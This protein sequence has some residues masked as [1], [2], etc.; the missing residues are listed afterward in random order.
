MVLSR[1]C[2]LVKHTHGNKC[3]QLCLSFL[4]S[5]GC[6]HVTTAIRDN[7]TFCSLCIFDLFVF[8]G[9]FF[10]VPELASLGRVFRSAAPVE[11]TESETEY[12]VRCVKHIMDGYVVLDFTISNTIEEQVMV[13]C[14]RCCRGLVGFTVARTNAEL[15]DRSLLLCACTGLVFPPCLRHATARARY[16]TSVLPCWR[17]V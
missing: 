1:R 3:L 10:Q 9:F 17:I 13:P 11:L 2:G 16:I 4:A 8:V 14:G 6:R 12:V 7:N 15:R 5:F